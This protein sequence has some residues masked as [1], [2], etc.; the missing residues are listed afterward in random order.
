MLK[1]D[2]RISA[3]LRGNVQMCSPALYLPQKG[4]S[5]NSRRLLVANNVDFNDNLTGDPDGN[6]IATNT[7]RGN[8][9]CA[10]NSPSPQIGDSAG[11]QNDV[12]GHA[13][14]QCV[15]PSLVR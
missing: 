14:G 15:N 8:L 6:E 3:R 1:S 10:G 12:F 9:S 11:G 4:R 5:V 13:H 2:S 7:I